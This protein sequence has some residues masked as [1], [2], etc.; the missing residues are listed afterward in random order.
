MK[1]GIVNVW[2]VVSFLVAIS[3]NSDDARPVAKNLNS[4]KMSLNE[5]LW[6]P[7][8]IDSCTKAFQCE[9]TRYNDS[10]FYIIQAYQ[11]PQFIADFNSEYQLRMQIMDVHEAGIY[12]LNEEHGVFNSYIRLSI[13]DEGGRKVYFNS[14]TGNSFKVEIKEFYPKEGSQIIGIGGEFSGTIYN[15]ENP[16]DSLKIKNGT[17]TFQKTNWHS[18][19]Q[20]EE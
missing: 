11:D 17:F 4:F 10:P 3:C 1:K 12:P 14:T 18:F 5:K 20:C 9:M 8:V 19:N 15:L 16:L 6:E 13:N 7:S 2:L